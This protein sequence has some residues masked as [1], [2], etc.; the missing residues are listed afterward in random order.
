M[1]INHHLK[2]GV[3]LLA[4]QAC[5][6]G[7]VTP[8]PL[9]S[10][11]KVPVEIAAKQGQTYLCEPYQEPQQPALHFPSDLAVSQDG[12]T[13]YALNGECLGQTLERNKT[14]G[15]NATT[16]C[17]QE[18]KTRRDLLENNG[19]FLL[20]RRFIY[21]IQ[22]NQ[23]PEILKIQGNP[24]L[25]CVLGTDLEIDTQDRL[26]AV[27]EVNQ[28]IYRLTDKLEQI[29]Q[30]DEATTFAVDWPNRDQHKQYFEAPFALSIS[31]NSLYF[32]LYAHGT[33]ARESQIRQL[34]L[35][36]AKETTIYLSFGYDMPKTNNLMVF[37]SEQNV[38]NGFFPLLHLK[39]YPTDWISTSNQ[40]RIKLL[41][42][43]VY[44]QFI[45]QKIDVDGIYNGAL[46]Y[47]NNQ[48]IFYFS[49][50]HKHVIYKLV[51][52]PS[53]EMLSFEVFAGSAEQM[54]D[55]DGQAAQ[56]RF[57]HPTAVS[58]DKFHHLYVADT[59]NHAIR[60][61]TP[62]GH[63]STFYKESLPLRITP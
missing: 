49:D 53:H 52:N 46:L 26:Y 21:K 18:S 39:P 19:V 36:S 45:K 57:K 35:D 58:L 59:G 1:K 38:Y 54:G 4:L 33:E 48:Y 29:K 32:S 40:E 22:Q 42:G 6:W 34:E 12:K 13:V 7:G 60:K 20:Q 5:Q 30:V 2:L 31:G 11:E 37:A 3:S 47:Q 17:A 61:I 15:M 56:A 23:K 44:D 43:P 55:S 8:S 62:D 50:T 16:G 25:N 9:P 51:V 10:G 28:G 24:P 14:L 27:D 63:V 41:S